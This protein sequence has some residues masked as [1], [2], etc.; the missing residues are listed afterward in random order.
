MQ[1]TNNFDDKL[2]IKSYNISNICPSTGD[3]LNSTTTAAAC[4]A[5]VCDYVVDV[6]SFC[7]QS[8]Y[9]NV[10]VSALNRLGRGAQSENI[11]AGRNNNC[12]PNVV[13]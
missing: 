6:S 9:I 8:S 11:I 1:N 5:E 10:T 4:M 3:F 2:R 7:H 12:K 13:E